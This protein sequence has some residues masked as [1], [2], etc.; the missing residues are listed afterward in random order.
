M[1]SVIL[2][3]VL[4]VKLGIRTCQD[5]HAVCFSGEEEKAVDEI[6]ADVKG[7]VPLGY[8][9]NTPKDSV[10][11]TYTSMQHKATCGLAD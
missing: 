10:V 9:S 1:P 4:M 2:V 8:V 3:T 6:I 11:N 5:C 7:S